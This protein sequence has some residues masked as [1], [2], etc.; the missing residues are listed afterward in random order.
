M[1]AKTAAPTADTS[2]PSTAD[3]D[4]PTLHALSFEALHA[5]EAAECWFLGRQGTP[6]VNGAARCGV[7]L[8][9][10]ASS[11]WAVAESARQRS[12]NS[13]R[14]AVI[15][16]L[17]KDES[18]K[19]QALSMAVEEDQR[20]RAEFLADITDEFLGLEGLAPARG[21]ARAEL[22]AWWADRGLGYLVDQAETFAR[23]WANF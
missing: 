19:A 1:P 15:G 4:L 23:G 6:L 20:I 16:L 21:A 7:R 13:G 8:Y 17:S 10:P 14:A 11:R 12:I 3:D 22:V 5:K 9:G 2:S 18:I